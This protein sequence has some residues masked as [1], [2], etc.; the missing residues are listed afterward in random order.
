MI[1]R[2]LEQIM[3]SNV[4]QMLYSWQSHVVD[5]VRRIVIG[6]ENEVACPFRDGSIALFRVYSWHH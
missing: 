3:K 5:K 6:S 2:R 1:S 4:S